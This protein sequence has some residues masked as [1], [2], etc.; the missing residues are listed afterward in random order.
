MAYF[1]LRLLRAIPQDQVEGDL[2]Y[3]M[4]D[5]RSLT[6]THEVVLKIA[7]QHEL[8]EHSEGEAPDSEKFVKQRDLAKK[9]IATWLSSVRT[10]RR[11]VE[12]FLAEPGIL[13]VLFRWG[14]LGSQSEVREFIDDLVA[15]DVGI[16]RF[17]SIWRE[18]SVLSDMDYLL[19]D[20]SLFK[21]RCEQHPR[22]DTFR[23]GL[24]GYLDA[25]EKKSS[26]GEGQK[27]L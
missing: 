11:N 4:A 17:L 9:A 25:L 13:G 20:V 7:D 8:R 18:S 5:Q 27:D 10:K 14:Q 24:W 16:E 15:S 26:E 6:L 21:R 12:S 23:K 22:R 1:I 3:L 19:S 2:L